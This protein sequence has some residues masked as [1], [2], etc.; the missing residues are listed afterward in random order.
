MKRGGVGGAVGVVVVL[1]G[2]MEVRERWG[3][4][5]RVKNKQTNKKQT[6]KKP[7]KEGLLSLSV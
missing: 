7:T 3:Y 6:H 2:G 1:V 5:G 4:G